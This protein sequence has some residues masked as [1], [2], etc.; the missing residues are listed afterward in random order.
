MFRGVFAGPEVLSPS[1]E[2]IHPPPQKAFEDED[3]NERSVRAQSESTSPWQ[4]SGIIIP[5]LK[6]Q[7]VEL[8][9]GRIVRSFGG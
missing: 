3:R 6:G 1:T 8:L 5:N 7:L 2:I 9:R 4:L